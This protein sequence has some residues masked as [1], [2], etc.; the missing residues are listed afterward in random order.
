MGPSHHCRDLRSSLPQRRLGS[1]VSWPYAFL[2]AWKAQQINS[3]S[4][5]F[6]ARG[7]SLYACPKEK[8][9]R[10]NVTPL[11]ACRASMPGKSVR[12]AGLFDR[13]SATAPALLYLGH[14]CPRLSWR[15]GA[16]IPV[17][18]P[19]RRTGA[20]GRAACHPGPHSGR[21]RCALAKAVEPRA[22]KPRCE[23]GFPLLPM[24]QFNHDLAVGESV[25][26]PDSGRS[27]LGIFN[28]RGQHANRRRP[29]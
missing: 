11:G 10:E 14:P 13:T 27:A 28:A 24:S 22:E 29:Q 2:C 8:Y 17:D 5:R 26:L 9:S 18:S 6:A 21:H 12:G 20:P 4:N 25:T 19:H 1:S 3:V 23:R 15:K 16:D 7:T